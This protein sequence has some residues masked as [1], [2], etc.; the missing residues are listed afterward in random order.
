MC[1][2]RDP[3]GESKGSDLCSWGSKTEVH[4]Q[5]HGKARGKS[6]NWDI[7][8]KKEC[9]DRQREPQAFLAFSSVI[10]VT[11]FPSPT[12][13][14]K[15]RMSIRSLS[16]GGKERQLGSRKENLTMGFSCAEI[17]NYPPVTGRCKSIY[18][19]F[20]YNTLTFL[21]EPFI[22]SA[23]GGNRNNFKHKYVCEHFCLPAK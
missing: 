20:Y 23:C 7:F 6:G 4:F 5:C 12:D 9:C 17:C 10:A 18:V 16:P 8:T 13:P 22:F 21:C 2:C 19:Q 3:G 15:P 1:V 11:Y 14:G